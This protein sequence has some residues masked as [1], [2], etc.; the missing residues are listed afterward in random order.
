MSSKPPEETPAPHPDAARG[1]QKAPPAYAPTH[2]DVEARPV[3]VRLPRPKLPGWYT[4]AIALAVTLVGATLLGVAAWIEPD[5]RGFGTHTQI[6]G[7]GVCGILIMTGYP[8]PTCGMTTA[9]ANTV[10]GRWL[11]AIW[12]QPAGFVFA[13]GTSG[14]VLVGTWVVATGRMPRFPR[15][16][17]LLRVYLTVLG[18]LI[19]GWAYLM[20][21][22]RADGRFPYSGETPQ[23]SATAGADPSSGQKE[24]GS[25][26]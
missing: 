3:D 15:Q 18:L 22:G 20:L 19:F 8:C 9:F 5:P 26:I 12:G 10:R 7:Q 14:A 25:G 2:L 17:T 1:S 11:T 23:T 6:P 13:I 21:V 24:P 16:V 4:R